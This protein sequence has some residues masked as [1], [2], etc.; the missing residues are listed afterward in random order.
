MAFYFTN[1]DKFILKNS[2]SIS[3]LSFSTMRLLASRGKSLMIYQEDDLQ[4]PNRTYE[5]NLKEMEEKIT[6]R[7]DYNQLSPVQNCKS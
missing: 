1:P 3:V 5:Q 6:L 7:T 4:E 2:D